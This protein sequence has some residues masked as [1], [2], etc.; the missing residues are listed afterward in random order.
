VSRSPGAV[1]FDLD[2]T[3]YPQRRFV[4]SGFAA[5]ARHV[6]HATG[7]DRKRVFLV[8]RDAWRERRGRELQACVERFALPPALVPALLGVMRGH[9]PAIRL[10]R[11]S[12]LAL[13]ALRTHWRTGIVTNGDPAIQRRKVDALGLGALVDSVVFAGEHGTGAGKPEAAPFAAAL[14]RLDAVAGRAVFVGNDEVCD[15]A[16]AAAVGMKTVLLVPSPPR[17]T[18]TGTR[19]DIVVHTIADVPQAVASL[20]RRP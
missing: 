6:E 15:I 4:F 16:G 13:M 3:L 18:A 12:A 7:E 8:L 9:R 20:M 14:D 1:L 5:V 2:D 11:R 10:P 19:A 17:A